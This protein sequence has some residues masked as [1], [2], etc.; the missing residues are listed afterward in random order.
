MKPDP[1]GFYR[2]VCSGTEER[3]GEIKRE[4][5]KTKVGGE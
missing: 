2:Y 3:R 5:G 4:E 1:Q